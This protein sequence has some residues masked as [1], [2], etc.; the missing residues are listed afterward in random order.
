MTQ[1]GRATPSSRLG[2]HRFAQRRVSTGSIGRSVPLRM[3][4]AELSTRELRGN[5]SADWSL[6]R[7]S[8]MRETERDTSSARSHV[9]PPVATL[10]TARRRRSSLVSEAER[11]RTGDEA[12]GRRPASIAS[13]TR[14]TCVPSIPC[15]CAQPSIP[16]RVR[17]ESVGS[18]APSVNSYDVQRE[19]RLS[20]SL[21]PVGCISVLGCSS[22]ADCC[23]ERHTRHTW[24]T[25]STEQRT[26]VTLMILPQVHLRKPCYDF[27][28]L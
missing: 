20:S 7:I 18:Y 11:E 17:R 3:R 24:T 14:R 12:R 9:I 15:A 1:S 2:Y 19:R 25:T 21:L 10:F 5:G 8:W 6:R 28:F 27:Y 4:I 22:V 26:S 13:D 16:G 23:E